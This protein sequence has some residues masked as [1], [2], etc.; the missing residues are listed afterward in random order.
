MAPYVHSCSDLTETLGVIAGGLAVVAVL[1]QEG[2]APPNPA[3]QFALNLAPELH[4]PERTADQQ[5]MQVNTLLPQP[6]AGG[7][8]PYI[9]YVGSL[10]TPP[11]SEDVQ[12]FIFADTVTIPGSQVDQFQQFASKANGVPANARPLQPL[13]NRTFDFAEF[14]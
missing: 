11:C 6:E 3:V 1:L 7:Q 9:H 5:S 14:L 10:T 13:N 8:R 4:A 2:T 12:W